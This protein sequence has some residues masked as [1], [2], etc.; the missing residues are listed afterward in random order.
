M[1]LNSKWQF[2]QVKGINKLQVKG[3]AIL[4]VFLVSQAFTWQASATKVK[5]FDGFPLT[6]FVDLPKN[7]K[8]KEFFVIAHGSGPMD[9]DGNLSSM[10][11]PKGSSNLVYKQIASVLNSIGYGVIRYHK[12]AYE[13]LLK[14][15]ADQSYMSSLEYKAFEKNPLTTLV[16]DFKAISEYTRKKFKAK[17][18]YG[19][20]HSEGTQV[21]LFAYVTGLKI[22]GMVLAGLHNERQSTL[23]LEQTTYRALKLYF[24]RV[25]QDKNGLVD[26]KEY[27]APNQNAQ[28]L[29][30]QVSRIDLNKDGQISRDEFLA[31][32]Y[33]N[34]IT[35]QITS[36]EYQRDEL[37]YPT[38]AKIIEAAS[39]PIS[40]LVATNDNQTPAYQVMAMDFLN[41]QV[42]KKKNLNFIY[43]QGYGHGL[44]RRAYE[45]LLFNKVDTEKL[46]ST[47][48]KINF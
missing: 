19:F 21:A 42:W 39:I 28:V 34:I 25:D 6:V 5:S 27:S 10:T 3:L 8:P 33:S 12:R 14:I 31:G 20:G 26:S 11:L 29:K 37:N 9:A 24:D 15:Q 41:R 32:N 17:K 35:Q 16:K 44:D 45:Q 30:Q 47:L 23:V 7:S 13:T 46:R 22:D 48:K 1:T 38:A 36:T 18:V 4:F 43:M 40:I 2:E